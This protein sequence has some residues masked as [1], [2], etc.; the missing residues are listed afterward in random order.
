[1]PEFEACCVRQAMKI[2]LGLWKHFVSPASGLA[3]GC[4]AWTELDWH[5]VELPRKIRCVR[6][7]KHRSVD[8]V[9]VVEVAWIVLDVT[10]RVTVCC[11]EEKVRMNCYLGRSD[12]IQELQGLFWAVEGSH[13]AVMRVLGRTDSRR[14]DHSLSGA[15]FGEIGEEN[16]D[17]QLDLARR[18]CKLM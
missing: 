16:L 7:G 5:R 10:A 9:E 14:G 15:C 2:V 8:L 17:A 4:C 13:R 1:M 6:E 12:V 11:S 18:A 3:L